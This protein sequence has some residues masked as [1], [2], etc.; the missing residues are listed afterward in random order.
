MTCITALREH[1]LA[2]AFASNQPVLKITI[3]RSARELVHVKPLWLSLLG[4]NNSTVFQNFDFNLLAAQLFAGREDPFIICAEAS[5]GAAIIPAAVRNSDNSLRLLGEELFDYRKFLHSGNEEVLREAIAVLAG[6]KKSL[7]I[8][9]LRDC[10]RDGVSAELTLEPF[11]AAPLVRCCDAE[12]LWNLHARLG[13]NLRR[14]QRLGYELKRYNGENPDLLR[15]IYR[16][17]ADQDSTSLF[18]DSLRAEFI[19]NAA[20]LRP[21]IFEIFTLECG[22]QIGAALV[23]LRD[24]DVRRFYTGWFAPEIARHSPA[25]TLIYEVSCESL[26][27]GMDC[28]YMT[29][30][31]PYKLRL[32]TASVPLYRLRATPEQLA[33]LVVPASEIKLAG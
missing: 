20:L 23:T 6:Q 4:R 26:A 7:E 9:A 21:E 18:H 32:A 22:A 5:Y 14:L 33:N 19:T 28:D 8:I 31:Q 24:G 10:D 11:S 1:P 17:K 3:C 2:G 29:G 16:A 25:L 13:R 15:A 12:S 27:A 30:E